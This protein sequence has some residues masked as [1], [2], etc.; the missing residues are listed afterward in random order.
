METNWSDMIA[1]LCVPVE[2]VLRD[3]PSPGFT[4]REEFFA[5]SYLWKME[6]EST[7]EQVIQYY[8]STRLLID[9]GLGRPAAALSRSIHE[10]LIRLDYLSDHPEELLD[11]FRWQLSRD[12][13]LYR[14]TVRYGERVSDEATRN[15]QQGM[16]LIEF[17]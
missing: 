16:G 7:C 15:L 14:D 8:R 2:E 6:I 12:Y 11:W 9:E 1:D 5:P 17:L 10:C 4:Y 3:W 13:H